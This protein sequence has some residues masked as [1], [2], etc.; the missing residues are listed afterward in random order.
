MK[1]RV[2]LAPSINA[3]NPSVDRGVARNLL[4][5]QTRGPGG[6]KSPVGVQGQNMETL[7]NTNGAWQILTYGVAHW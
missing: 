5:G 7:E 3:L 2:R 6:R 1:S 4:R